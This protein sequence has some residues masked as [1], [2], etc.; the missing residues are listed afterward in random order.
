MIAVSR[1]I[2]QLSNPA[3]PLTPTLGHSIWL[4]TLPKPDI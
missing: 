2:V 3:M 4:D 1:R